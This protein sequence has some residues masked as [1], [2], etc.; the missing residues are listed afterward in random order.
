MGKPEN[1]SYSEPVR[2][3]GEAFDRLQKLEAA[4]KDL[5]AKFEALNK[6]RLRTNNPQELDKLRLEMG[7]L[8]E[9]IA[10]LEAEKKQAAGLVG[11]LMDEHERGQQLLE[12]TDPKRVN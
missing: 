11:S 5:A 9:Q 1:R 4:Q 2:K 12:N 10:S 6:A 3:A 7:W 8:S